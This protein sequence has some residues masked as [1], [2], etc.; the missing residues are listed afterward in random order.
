MAEAA[1][2]PYLVVNE[3]DA[4]AARLGEAGSVLIRSG[5]SLQ[6]FE[7]L[8]DA[9][10]APIVHP[11]T[12]LGREAI[13]E[14]GT[15]STVNPGQ[16]FIPLH[17]E[18]AYSPAAPDILMFYCD[19]PPSNGGETILC[20]GV[21]LR[22]E[23]SNDARAFVD[24]AILK[25]RWWQPAESW[26]A[27]LGTEDKAE[28]LERLDELQAYLPPYERLEAEFDGDTLR[29][30][31]LT[32]AVI[33]TRSGDAAAFCN[34]VLAY[35]NQGGRD[36]FGESGLELS[37]L[38]D[39][40]FPDNVLHEL[41]AAAERVTQPVNWKK[42]DIVVVDNIRVMHGRRAFGGRRRI[43]VRMGYVHDDD[44]ADQA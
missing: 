42:G 13:S 30:S 20:D 8:S 10:M 27:K 3:A 9:L 11:V 33:P 41:H 38:D 36:F 32:P 7:Q 14:D 31:F 25:W 43:F 12:G 18:G 1:V 2:S 21:V 24:G 40:A 26:R 22:E 19:T 15:T 35:Y 37:L 16:D 34:S 5:A 17:R 23:L 39:S 28:A 6:K 44:E 4:V 29:G